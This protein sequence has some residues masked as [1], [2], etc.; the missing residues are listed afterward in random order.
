[1]SFNGKPVTISYDLEMTG[2]PVFS[3]AFLAAM[4]CSA[5]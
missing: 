5:N 3:K 1:M 2:A 4:R